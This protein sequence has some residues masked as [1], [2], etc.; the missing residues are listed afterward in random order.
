MPSEKNQKVADVFPWGSA[1]PPPAGAGNFSGEETVGKE[2]DKKNQKSLTGYRDDFVATAP[3][4]SFPANRFGLFDLSGNVWE[5]CEDWFDAVK[6]DRVLRGGSW[7]SYDRGALLSSYR[8]RITPGSRG[9]N[10]GFR[11]VVAGSAP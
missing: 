3:V 9:S 1:W 10:R 5:W 4:G 6:T 8:S 7:D 11:C 2:I